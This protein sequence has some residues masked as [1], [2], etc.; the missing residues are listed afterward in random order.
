[1]M[2]TTLTQI[3]KKTCKN[4]DEANQLAVLGQVYEHTVAT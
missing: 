4:C 1:M 3:K 2:Y